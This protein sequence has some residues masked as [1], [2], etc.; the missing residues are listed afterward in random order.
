MNH[1]QFIA[2]RSL[3]AKKGFAKLKQQL[4]VAH[5]DL[6]EKDRIIE[7]LRFDLANLVNQLPK[8]KQNHEL[9][10]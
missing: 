2:V 7:G 1:N 9:S 3:Y 10:I 4:V 6:M 8:L 5:Q